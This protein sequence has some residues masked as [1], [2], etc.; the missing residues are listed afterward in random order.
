MDQGKEDCGCG[1]GDKGGEVVEIHDIRSILENKKSWLTL[2][3]TTPSGLRLLARIEDDK[4]LEWIV[5]DPYGREVP[6]VIYEKKAPTAPAKKTCRICVTIVGQTSCWDVPCDKI[7]ILPRM[8]GGD[9]SGGAVEVHDIRPILKDT[10]LSEGLNHVF[11]TPSGLRFSARVEGGEVAE[12]LA[13]DPDGGE[14]PTTVYQKAPAKPK[15]E[16]I[17]CNVCTT[18]GGKTTCVEVPCGKILILP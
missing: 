5:Q 4:F 17:K 11:T 2:I 13:H 6:T 12:W 16:P 15:G 9:E 1:S 7:V 10:P 8:A 3:H 14:I 18:E